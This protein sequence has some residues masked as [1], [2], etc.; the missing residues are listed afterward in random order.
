MCNGDA[1]NSRYFEILLKFIDS[2]KYIG[3]L[4]I[5]PRSELIG[6]KV[7]QNIEESPWIPLLKLEFWMSY[8]SEIM[9]MNNL[10]YFR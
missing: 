9:K 4:Q 7:N 3:L 2:Y 5:R 1:G 6:Q 10:E 8:E